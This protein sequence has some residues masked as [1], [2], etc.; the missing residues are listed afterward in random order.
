MPDK[1]FTATALAR[2]KPLRHKRT[3]INL[4]ENTDGGRR[5]PHQCPL[6]TLAYIADVRS[7]MMTSSHSKAS[8]TAL[9]VGRVV[10]ARTGTAA[11]HHAVKRAVSHAALTSTAATPSAT[12]TI[13]AA[14][15]QAN[16]PAAA[17][18]REGHTRTESS[19]Q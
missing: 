19:H 7:T 3:I 17:T 2:L 5:T 6:G 1:T 9:V 15:T 16:S 4:L 12:T 11:A 13:V 14:H 8:P 10:L 18:S